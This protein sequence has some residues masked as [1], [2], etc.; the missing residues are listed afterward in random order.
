[1]I[2]DAVN[3]P[4]AAVAGKRLY[5][6]VRDEMGT[7]VALVAEE[8]P[9]GPDAPAVPVRY[10]YTPYGEAH[11]E[12]GPEL[13]R[14]VFDND[15]GAVQTP[16][17][18]VEQTVA[19]ATTTSGGALR[20]RFSA[21]LD[22]S[23][24]ATGIVVEALAGGVWTAVPGAVVAADPEVP[25]DVL[26]LAPEGWTRGTSYRVAPTSALRDRFGR[27]WQGTG[28]RLEWRVP[29][30]DPDL[31]S[32]PT[33]YE[34]RFAVDYESFVAAGER[35][36]GRIP[37]GQSHLFQ[38]LWTDPVTGISYARARWYDARNASFL[39]EDPL[40]DVA[41]PNLYAFVAWQPTWPPIRRARSPST[42]C[43][44]SVSSPGTW[45][46]SATST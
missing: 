26:A 16:A 37:G 23:T 21:P 7:V 40:Q 14:V 29:E 22:E 12:L 25:G 28:E 15:V 42:P 33:I 10:L 9:S 8:E 38:G 43:S 11:A 3:D 13:R 24:L 19:D 5:T 39:S 6:Y 35:V 4:S 17:G 46:S 20:L 2:V 32:T 27:A 31:I 34:R 36:G 44:T 18:E 1:M 41:S 30:H 45:A